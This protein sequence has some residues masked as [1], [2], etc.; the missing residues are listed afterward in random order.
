[1]SSDDRLGLEKKKYETRRFPPC[2]FLWHK[3]N[4]SK[5]GKLHSRKIK[6]NACG[7]LFGKISVLILLSKTGRLYVVG[8]TERGVF[9]N[10]SVRGIKED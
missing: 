4:Y 5:R 1:M 2:N 3:V 7:E 8:K 10:F 6:R 9:Y